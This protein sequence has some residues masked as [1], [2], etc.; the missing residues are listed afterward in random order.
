M[1]RA[2]LPYLILLLVFHPLLRQACGFFTQLAVSTP[3]PN[4]TTSTARSSRRPSST[5]SPAAAACLTQRTRFDAVFALFFL[6]ALH[7]FS[8]LKILTIL[9]LNYLIAKRVPRRYVPAATWAFNIGVL[10]ANEFGNGYRFAPLGRVLG[11]MLPGGAGG[12]VEGLGQWM[13]MRR[14]LIQRWEILFNITVLRLISFNMDH[15]WSQDRTHAV[16]PEVSF[17]TH[18]HSLFF[19]LSLLSLPLLPR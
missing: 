4:S 8:A 5:I 15:Y 16:S 11:S 1:F 12:L 18:T 7:G 10:F 2:N 9:T 6:F 13:D 14:G 19:S 3:A 17:H